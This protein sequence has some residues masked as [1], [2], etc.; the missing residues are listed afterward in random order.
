MGFIKIL[1]F[2]WPFVKEL[3]L[4][5]KTLIEALKTNKKKVFFAALVML[6]F[7]INIFV[8]PKLVAI[9]NN[10]VILQR[11]HDAL[12]AK[13]EAPKTSPIKGGTPVH[14]EVAP[15]RAP[16]K[17]VE[18]L[19]T[20]TAPKETPKSKPAPSAERITRLRSTFDEIRK[21]EEQENKEN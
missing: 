16:V 21:Q 14:E 12:K 7:A 17:T 1:T 9:S 18:T 5:D 15:S 20:V 11:E 19:P 8:V 13:C 2:L 4:G 6:S 3:T 10:H